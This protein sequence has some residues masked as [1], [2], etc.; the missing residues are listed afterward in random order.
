MSR[1]LTELGLAVLRDGLLDMG[2][3]LKDDGS[4]MEHRH[5]PATVEEWADRW[6]KAGDFETLNGGCLPTWMHDEIATADMG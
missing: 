1:E 4:I 2:Y 6:L 5:G 3:M